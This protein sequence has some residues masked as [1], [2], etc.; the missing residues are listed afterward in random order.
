MLRFSCAM[1]L[2]VALLAHGRLVRLVV[3]HTEAA[4]TYQRLTG[5]FTGALDPKHEGNAIINDISLAPRN[6]A[7]KV[8]YSATFSLLRPTD[9]ARASGVLWYE[10]PNRGNSPLN[11]RPSPD[12]LAAGHIL[13]SSG[14]QGDLTPRAGLETITVPVAHPPDGAPITGPVLYRIANVRGATASLEAGYAALRY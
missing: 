8:E 1:V 14:W 9:P 3:E 6:A 2:L 12:A 10:V 5:H 4:G 11:P 13:V 7:G